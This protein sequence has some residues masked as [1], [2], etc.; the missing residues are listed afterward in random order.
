MR[1]VLLQIKEDKKSLKNIFFFDIESISLK[2]IIIIYYYNNLD[3][4][5]KKLQ[6]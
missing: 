1:D 3:F 6:Y 4:W 2:L 5:K